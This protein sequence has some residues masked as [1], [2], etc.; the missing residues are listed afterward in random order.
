M[1][2]EI[3]KIHKAIYVLDAHHALNDRI[4]K[5]VGLR[6]CFDKLVVA[7]AGRGC[8]PREKIAIRPLINPE[9]V[10]LRLKLRSLNKLLDKYL[11]FPSGKIFFVKAAIKRLKTEIERD[12]NRGRKVALITCL[13]PHDLVA[14]GLALKRCFP[15]IQWIIDWQ[16]LWSYDENYYERTAGYYRKKLH[17][18]EW[19]ALFNSDIN[20]T[21]NSYAKR[22]LEEHYKVPPERVVAISHHYSRDD[23]NDVAALE[24]SLKVGT[25]KNVLKIGFLGTLFKPPRVPGQRVA[26]AV[27]Y[28]RSRGLNVE[29]H[30][31]GNIPKTFSQMAK[32]HSFEGV[33]MHGNTGHKASLSS[34]SQCDF[35][36]LILADLHNSRVV[37]SIK[38]PHYLLIGKPIIAIVPEPSAVAD[39]VKSTRSGYVIPSDTNWLEAFELVLM[40]SQK[41]SP[42]LKRNEQA[43]E[44]FSWENISR[45]W[46]EILRV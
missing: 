45:L 8:V 3:N 27:K 38:L 36:L 11:F 23:L 22:V 2:A 30:V 26:E 17:Q 12:L 10:L 37:M 43:V 32:K 18:L 20:V 41:D 39:I 31:F 29:L 40:E 9:A 28:V 33:I 25:S 4:E 21:T 19:D 44:A 5:V 35:L 7:Q 24:T 14:S 34:I 1:N 13:P 16:D 15:E 6:K 42:S 46:M